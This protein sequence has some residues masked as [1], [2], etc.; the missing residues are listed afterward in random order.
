MENEQSGI[1]STVSRRRLL[2]GGGALGV[3]V[4]AGAVMGATPAAA[5]DGNYGVVSAPNFYPTAGFTPEVDVDGKTVVITGGSRG[6]GKATGERLQAAGATVFGTSRT[7]GQYP[8]HP[9]P[10][11]ELDLADPSSIAAFVPAVLGA[12]G[13]RID[14]LFN[15]AGRFAFGYPFPLDAAGASMYFSGLE[16]TV[17]TLYAGHV[18][19]TSSLLGAVSTAAASG[20]G[21]IVFT[22]SAVAYAVGG[23]D[24]GF[25]FNHPYFS[26]KRSLL[27]YANCLRAIVAGTGVKVSTLNPVAINT[28]L[29]KGDRPIFLNPID[30]NFE[31]FL[32]F[33]RDLLAN[34]V[35]ASLPAEAVYQ[36]CASDDPHPNVAAGAAEEPFAT[37]GGNAL[38]AEVG[39]AEMLESAFPWVVDKVK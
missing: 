13:G 19:V 35:P 28:D 23:T 2:L 30:A 3:G 32:Q 8:D 10:L 20:Y 4:A 29:A 15:N 17:A 34:G 12:T 27:A 39:R 16:E 22:C 1:D 31:L 33:I 37:Q 25:S 14:V 21:R 6:I 24:P 7:P 26:G 5:K 11:L 9:F 38:L 36:L 18:A